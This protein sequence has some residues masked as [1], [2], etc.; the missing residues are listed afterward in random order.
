LE[1]FFFKDFHYKGDIVW[2]LYDTYGFPADLTQLMCEERG[3]T[4]DINLF[5]QARQKSLIASQQTSGE[6]NQG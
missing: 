2:R 6:Q 5:E 3:L 1:K 4:F